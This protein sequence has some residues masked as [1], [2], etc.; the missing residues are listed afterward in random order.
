MISS[1]NSST[2]D[3]GFG[4]LIFLRGDV[5][6]ESKQKIRNSNRHLWLKTHNTNLGQ[7]HPPCKFF[8][9]YC[10][11]LYRTPVALATF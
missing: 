1:S 7:M 2:V 9:P 10:T 6:L 5:N 11:V 4:L 8:S 3:F